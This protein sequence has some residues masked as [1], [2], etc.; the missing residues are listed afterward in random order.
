M[1][2][3]IIYSNK[4]KKIS[5]TYNI[6][7]LLKDKVLKNGRVFE[8]YLPESMPHVC[9]GCYACIKGN[10]E[11]CGGY[12]YLEPIKQAIEASD[13]IVFCSPVYAYHISGQMKTLLD[14]FAY[15]WMVHRFNADMMKKQ[16]VIIVT[17]GG[18]GLKSAVK[19]IKDSL[20]FWGIARTHVITQSVWEYDWRNMP[21]KFKKSIIKKVEKVSKKILKY[22]NDLVPSLKVRIIFYIFRYLHKNEKMNPID[23]KYWLDRGYTT[24]KQPWKI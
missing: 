19:D 10:E 14:H 16:S 18:G 12:S 17:A 8:F 6:A 9:T 3:T 23:D 22:E 1:N 2:I 24:G 20:D 4:R 5:S 15:M 7:Q 21:E 11:K 13:L